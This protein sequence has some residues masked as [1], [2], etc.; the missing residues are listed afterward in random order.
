MDGKDGMNSGDFFGWLS[1]SEVAR[2]DAHAKE[3]F[4]LCSFECLLKIEDRLPNEFVVEK[5]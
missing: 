5:S 1:I 2:V 3:L 4:D